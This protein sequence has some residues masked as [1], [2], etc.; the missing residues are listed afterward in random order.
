MSSIIA[1]VI[2][3]Y[4]LGVSSMLISTIEEFAERG[5]K[6][7]IFIDQ[8]EF[9]Y[10]PIVFHNK[11][12]SIHLLFDSFYGNYKRSANSKLN[13]SK[14]SIRSRLFSSILLLK[15][16]GFYY[17]SIP[18]KSSNWIKELLN[19]FFPDYANYIKQ[20]LKY[21]N[22]NYNYII[23]VEPKGAYAAIM[24]ASK[25]TKMVSYFNMELFQFSKSHS[26]DKYL[27][28]V[29]EKITIQ[30]KLCNIVFPNENRRDIF[31]KINNF[32]KRKTNILPV[33]ERLAKK[34]EPS[35]Y[36]YKILNI[37]KTKKIVLYA[38][39]IV[40]WAMCLEVI[41]SMVNWPLNYVL[42]FHTY[43]PE[44]RNDPYFQQL[45]KEAKDLPVY[46]STN[47]L[48][49]SELSKLISSAFI[50]LLFYRPKD[51]NFIEIA[52]SSNKLSS[53]LKC[54]VPI[55]YNNNSSLNGLIQKKCG[56]P[57]D[58]FSEISTALETISKNYNYFK[59][60]A[61]ELYDAKFNFIYYF[62]IFYNNTP[63]KI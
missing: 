20:I 47:P 5:Y 52:M 59:N 40:E 39:N 35:D 42:V 51:E 11:N 2:I 22:N 62:N 28:E 12:I 21:K 23:G 56:L 27:R 43:V 33:A 60:N 15:N 38:G 34:T 49:I 7:D 48:D 31:S 36:L 6:V 53:Y 37:D 18:F 19:I 45:L 3:N 46:F 61:Y 44:I 29:L 55:L 41:Q 1:I 58:N 17:L 50:G 26:R 16:L 24:L 32:P 9:N 14:T 30:H 54:G 13:N 63:V 25:T 57:I 10:S 8:F 4:P